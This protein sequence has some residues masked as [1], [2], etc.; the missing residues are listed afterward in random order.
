ML[1]TSLE[2]AADTAAAIT[3]GE[4]SMSR[5]E[6]AS[7]A[8]ALATALP[9]GRPV[10]VHAEATL[11]TVIAVTACLLAGVPVVPIP[12][13]SGHAE[14]RH[15][16]DDAD[17]ACWAGPAHP[18]SDLPVVPARAHAAGGAIRAPADDAIAMILYTSGT[19]GAPKGVGLSHRAL[20]AGIDASP[21]SPGML[22]SSVTA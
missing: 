6:L 12:P 20:A 14:L 4:Q 1:L 13:D 15:I 7:A 2:S 19:T 18:D 21:S 8:G 3:I 10:A 17:I 5:D 9:S 11:E 16:L 22:P